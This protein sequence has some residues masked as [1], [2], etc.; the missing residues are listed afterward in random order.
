MNFSQWNQTKLSLLFLS[1]CARII[2]F[3]AK[4]DTFLFQHISSPLTKWVMY[5]S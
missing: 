4:D 3:D 1:N 2:F 5:K